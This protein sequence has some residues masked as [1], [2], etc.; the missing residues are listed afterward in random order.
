MDEK[1]QI[2]VTI[3]NKN[4]PPNPGIT[5]E[6]ANELASWLIARG[7]K[8]KT[9]HTDGLYAGGSSAT[10]SAGE[11]ITL[12]SIYNGK[13]K[14][15]RLVAS[16]IESYRLIKKARDSGE[17]LRIIMTDPPFLIFWSSLLLKNNTWAY[18]SMDLYPE[19]F[20]SGNLVTKKNILYKQFKRIT[21]NNPPTYLIALGERQLN[22]LQAEYK[23]GIKSSTV[24]PCGINT[25]DFSIVMTKPDWK[26][27]D[28]KIYIG[29]CGNLGEAHSAMFV[30]NVISFLDPEKFTMILS[31][32][33][34]K[35][36]QVLSIAQNKPG[37][38]IVPRVERYQL[39]LIDVHMVTLLPR[40]DNICVPSKAVSA[41]CEGG[42]I[43]FCGSKDNDNWYYLQN[44]G[45]FIEDS[46]TIEIAVKKWL[47]DI[48]T[49]EI[50]IKKK[51]AKKIAINLHQIKKEAFIQIESFAS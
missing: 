24:L 7:C 40:W 6:S 29:Y 37:I 38:I 33:G 39:P 43:L 50:L 35:A 34:S 47:S 28:G 44:A 13:N 8:V 3:V 36:Q 14:F 25:S 11:S 49:D 20:V 42:T 16:F 4:Y 17:G 32:Y 12:K 30:F 48:S 2:S 19:A 18:W 27:D 46:D 45:W 23:S 22:F 10:N 31:V 9:I 21:R 51:E 41:V 15:I 1:K 5:G 26:K